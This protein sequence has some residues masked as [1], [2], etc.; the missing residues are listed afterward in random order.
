MPNYNHAGFLSQ[1]LTAIL[2]QSYPIKELIVVD[3]AS[4]DNSTQIIEAMARHHP[5]IRLFRNPRNQGVC[6]TANRAFE[7]TTGDYI[8][9]AGAD[10]R[11]LPGFFEKTMGLLAAY[12]QAGLC[13]SFGATI[14]GETAKIKENRLCWSD[15][16]AY[17]GPCQL[18]RAL[19]AGEW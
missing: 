14:C 11:V 19:R 2:E 4:I 12:P 13:C 18:A 3:D 10:D 1:S 9:C 15:R 8:Y 16:P 6:Y 17:L 7:E 5:K